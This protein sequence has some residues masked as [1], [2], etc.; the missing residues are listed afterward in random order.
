MCA[1]LTVTAA[2]APDEEDLRI[3][4][5]LRADTEPMLE[6]TLAASDK[7]KQAIVPR[8]LHLTITWN[9]RRS[10]PICRGIP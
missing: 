3:A 4:T 5:L 1:L 2:E 10:W 7:A 6:Q 8:T 9:K